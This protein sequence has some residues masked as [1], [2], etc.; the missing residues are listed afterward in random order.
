MTENNKSRLFTQHKQSNERLHQLLTAF[1]DKTGCP[2]MINTSFNVRGEPIVE[3]I[4]DA[5]RCFMRTKIDYLVLEGFVLDKKQ[6]PK[7][8]ETQDW[9]TILKMD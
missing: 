8:E 3:S 4:E 7:Y 9:K 1:K 6:Q 2:I 5:Y